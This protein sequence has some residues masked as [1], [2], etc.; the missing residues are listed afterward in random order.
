MF[1]ITYTLS[2]SFNLLNVKN[3]IYISIVCKI[4]I[5]LLL[6]GFVFMNIDVNILYLI[7]F[8]WVVYGLIKSSN[9]SKSLF[10]LF[11]ICQFWN[12]VAMILHITIPSNICIF[13]TLILFLINY[14][15]SDIDFYSEC[16]AGNSKD[17][18][19]ALSQ[20]L[21]N[22]KFKEYL[23]F[24]GGPKG[25][26]PEGPDSK[27]LPQGWDFDREESPSESLTTKYKNLSKDIDNHNTNIIVS[28]NNEIIEKVSNINLY[29]DYYR[30]PYSWVWRLDHNYLQRADFSEIYSNRLFHSVKHDLISDIKQYNFL[31]YCKVY[32]ENKLFYSLAEKSI[33]SRD[34]L[35]N[36]FWNRIYYDSILK[37]LSESK[38]KNLWDSWQKSQTSLPY[39]EYML[40][41]GSEPYKE[42]VH[43]VNMFDEKKAYFEVNDNILIIG[44]GILCKDYII[45]RLENLHSSD[46][47]LSKLEFYAK[48]WEYHQE[49]IQVFSKFF[50]HYNDLCQKY[51]LKYYDKNSLEGA[52]KA[53]EEYKKFL[54]NTHL[55]DY[56]IDTWKKVPGYNWDVN[57]EYIYPNF[58]FNLYSPIPGITKFEHAFT[59]KD[60]FT[61]KPMEYMSP[62]DY[63]AKYREFIHDEFESINKK[64]KASCRDIRDFSYKESHKMKDVLLFP[65]K[66]FWKNQWSSK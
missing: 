36:S 18:L 40:K 32:Y 3:I 37:N 35:H 31:L 10:K 39:A 59:A 2:V 58:K 44:A 62:A 42:G 28:N 47:N 17:I 5:F 60:F 45:T 56:I 27:Y 66:C 46:P 11:F 49:S 61:K 50:N 30:D 41:S 13:N 55:A 57:P 43:I 24:P 48:A 6:C 15:I 33:M 8:I 52:I 9:I 16:D 23:N 14:I 53:N 20:A 26:G 54:A 12:L 51:M 25:P 1:T 22:I 38:Y 4:V 29:I 7:L 34:I 64:Y 21:K 19:D 65:D 63:K